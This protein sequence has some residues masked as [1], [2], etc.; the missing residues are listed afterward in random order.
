MSATEQEDV[1]TVTFRA[2][3]QLRGRQRVTLNR[4]LR[5]LERENDQASSNGAGGGR[6]KGRSR[7]RD[8]LPYLARR[9][10]GRLTQRMWG[11]VGA[12]VP[13]HV[14]STFDVGVLTPFTSMPAHL[15]EG[16]AIGIQSWDQGV[17][18]F[19]PWAAYRAKLVTSVGL[20]AWGTMGSGKTYAM[21]SA[22]QRLVGFGRHVI[23][24]EDPKGDWAPLA[25]ALG[26]QVVQIGP[27]CHTPNNPLAAPT[28]RVGGDERAARRQV[29]G[30]RGRLLRQMVSVLREGKPFTEDEEPCLDAVVEAIAEGRCRASIP[31]V[32]GFLA[33]P[34]AELTALVG[35]ATVATVHL[36]LRR[37]VSG[38]LAGMVDTEDELVLD[39]ASPMIVFDTSSM[40]GADEVTKGIANACLSA[41]VDSLLQCG[42]GR[43]RIVIDEEAWA[44]LR[45]PY[46]AQA[47]DN[48]LRMTGHWRCSPWLIFH[49]LND[50]NQMADFGAH[51]EIVRGIISKSQIKV[52]FRQSP[53]ALAMYREFVQPSDR[54]L[55]IVANLP[56]HEGLWRLGESVSVRV[57]ARATPAAHALFDNDEGRSG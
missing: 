22:A 27:G 47:I 38:P 31:A 11:P 40:L 48:R 7:E 50:I 51:R 21:Q 34:P 33:D 44:K 25:H 57:Q 46:A 24:E 37:L 9:G 15:L 41:R 54:E 12:L 1:R 28:L 14:T 43:F 26:G 17:F 42:D 30:H 56:P 16:P 52:V 3:P 5:R 39:P 8:D 35:A 18:R 19:D 10:W 13:M 53:A 32:V 36:V 49:E 55:E 29:D 6:R 45:N 20:S 23:V 4:Y 2:Y